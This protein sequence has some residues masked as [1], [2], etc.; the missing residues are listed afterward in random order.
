MTR[1]VYVNGRYVSYARANVH[2]EDRGFQFGDAVYEVVEIKSGALIDEERHLARLARSLAELKIPPPM[3]D[4]SLRHVMRQ[5]IGKNRV[6][7]GI[8]YLQV[9]RGAAPRDFSLPEKTL[10]PTLVCIAR[11]TD[12][13]RIA[14]T[15]SAGIAVITMPE[16]RW[17]RCDIKTVMLLPAVLAK[18]QARGRGAKEAWFLDREGL[19]TEGASS[20]A[21][22]VTR[23]GDVITRKADAAILP[24][25]TR[26]TLIDL[27]K[28]EG[29]AFVERAFTR[30]EALEA[31]EA[32]NTSASGTVMPV[33]QID[34][35]LIGNGKPGP[36]TRRLRAEFHSAAQMVDI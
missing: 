24:G 2:V 27:L 7:N 9:T 10:A 31:A 11:R 28:R 1:I 5:T 29:L 3:S 16:I 34:G 23:A 6:G 36:L 25:V 13:A 14:A 17:Q 26:R 22:I 8:V 15:A 32:F 35:I 19:V 21:W 12:G 20:N 33:V 18:E 30:S 4:A